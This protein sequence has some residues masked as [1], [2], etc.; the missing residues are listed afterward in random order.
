M[1]IHTTLKALAVPIDSLK[2]HPNNPREGDIGAISQSLKANGQYRPIVVSK[3][4]SRILAGN[5]TWKAAQALGWTEIAATFVNV[6]PEQ[7]TRIMLADNRYAELA[8]YADDSLA[9]LLVELA[10]TEQGLLGS[11]WDGDDLDQ[12]M[13]DLTGSE[14]EREGETK[15]P[16]ENPVT[17]LGDVWQLGLHTVT[18]GDA[19]DITLSGD[20]IVTDPP[21]GMNLDTDY[22]KMVDREGRTGNTYKPV[23][24][25][26]TPFNPSPLFDKYAHIKEQC[27]FGA[28]Y[29]RQHLPAGGS[30]YVWDKRDTGDEATTPGADR[31]FGSQFE[32]IWTRTKRRREILR[33][34][35]AGF[36]GSGVRHHPTQKPVALMERLIKL[37]DSTT[38]LDPFGG[39][40]TTLIAAENLGRTCHTIELDPAYCDVIVERYKSLNT[41]N[42]ILRNGK[43][44]G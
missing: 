10:G 42:P 8:T 1:R 9:E 15:P 37:S 30:W 44:H 26:D 11:G 17:E 18:C 4:T 5:H 19:F 16:P 20:A 6:T 39:S 13:A 7:E 31:L 24:G 28:D 36:I 38:I 25:D 40:G 27:W 43:P 33:H 41:G 32:L 21:Y 3:K 34:L 22:S 14:G 29:Y 23:I 2:P 12:L 35:W